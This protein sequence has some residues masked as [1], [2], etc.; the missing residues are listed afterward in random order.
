MKKTKQSK[1]VWTKFFLLSFVA[2]VFM[3]FSGFGQATDLI[4]SEYIEGS[5]NN[6]ALEV[7]NGT[8][9]VVDLTLYRFVRYNNGGTGTPS[10]TF[11]FVGTLADGA[12]YVIANPSADAAILA[13]ADITSTITYFNGD[14]YIALE[15]DMAGT[16]TVMDVI[17]VLGV[18]PGSCWPVADVA[19]GTQEHTLV[20]KADVCSP[21]TDWATSAGTNATDS[22]WIVYAQNDFSYIGAHTSSCSGGPIPLDANFSADQTSVEVGTTVN[23]T[24]LTSGG[25][26]PYSYSWD[27]NGDG[28][29]DANTQNP[30]YQYN[31]AGIYTVSLTV[32]DNISAV[33]TETK[34]DYIT[35]YTVTPV[36]NIAALRAGV[37]G[38]HYTLSNEVILTYQQSYRNQKYIEDATA[39]I[40]IDDN[41]GTITTTY[42]LDDGITGITGTLGE[43]GNMMQFIPLSDP[44]AA[45]SSG[46]TITPQTITLN[47]LITNF[48]MYEAELVEV[49]DVS[50]TDAGGTF[51]NG[52]VY[53]ISD[54]SKALYN[55]RTTFYSVDYIGGLIPAVASIVCLPNSRTDGE[56]ITSRDLADF[57]TPA[58]PAAQLAVTMVNGGTNPDENTNFSVTVQA[59]DAGGL[60]AVVSGNVNFTFTT[61]GGDLGTVAFVGG[62]TITGTI[63]DGD[64]EVTVTGV[65]MAPFGTNVTI[66]A[67]DDATFGGLTAGTSAPFDVLEIL[68]FVTPDIMI[69]EVMQNPS[70]VNDTDGEW[71]EL[72]NTTANPI[73]LNGWIIRDN[74]TN[75]DTIKSSVIVPAQGFVTLGKNADPLLN[76][77]YTCDY[78]YSSGFF[79]GNSSDAIILLR[80]DSTFVNMVEWDN[81]VEFPDP[82][83]A[84]MV[85][86]GT[87]SDDNNVGAMWTTAT[88]REPSYVGATGDLGS[89]GSN[90][91]DQNLVSGIM[92]DITVNLEGPYDAVT[93]TMLTSLFDGGYIPIT[94]PYGQDPYYGGTPIWLYTGTETVA[95]VPAGVVD[96]ALVQLRDADAPGNASSAT[97][98]GTQAAFL[99]ADGSIVGL[100]GSSKLSFNVTVSQ[101]LYAVVY[102]RNHLGIMSATGLTGLGGTYTY[103]FT[104]GSDK[105]FGGANGYKE[106]ETNVWGMVAGDGNASG[107]VDNTDESVVWKSDLGN[108]GYIGGDF[109][110]N[111]IVENTDESVI[112]K[113]NLNVGGQVPAKANNGYASQIPK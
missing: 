69:T 17:G 96:W 74:G 70:A 63:L 85:F 109:S 57:T 46:N 26:S 22:Q 51:A 66:T 112:W 15:K 81:G 19:C 59:Q 42:S 88:L 64:F 38:E 24:D 4:I 50:F 55:F 77:D 78:Q 91:S 49:M 95:T 29:E 71:F 31:T 11:N 73:D 40:M 100:D 2:I 8:G 105:V 48:E 6:K 83:G 47:D 97:I 67:T 37:I 103:D 33:N 62:T 111:G 82:N 79:L 92:I 52:T 53:P 21:T 32:T 75:L 104:T 101:N 68:P 28:F 23:F 106:L 107:I 98:L 25:T 110:L 18:D 54:G 60:P 43:Y 27:F 93:H 65:Q 113:P 72:F 94:Q 61:N 3:N 12:V 10:G 76:G 89:P 84:S 87:V 13:V 5:S 16:W 45:T 1:S 14:D 56:Y 34:V 108:S 30:S 9:A 99:L 80:P 7:Y 36:S 39:A 86:T 20:R 102:H 44:G 90:G 41:A 35:V 58:N